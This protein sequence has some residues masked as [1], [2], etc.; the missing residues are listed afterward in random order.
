MGWGEARA[1][2]TGQGFF[3]KTM[4]RAT[5]RDGS[6]VGRTGADRVFGSCP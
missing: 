1:K 2:S 5:G 4:T 3:A 6:D